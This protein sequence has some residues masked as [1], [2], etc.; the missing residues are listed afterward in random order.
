[1]LFHSGI[2]RQYPGVRVTGDVQW[3]AGGAAKSPEGLTASNV[4]LPRDTWV[5]LA[6]VKNVAARQ[7]LI[8][9]DGVEVA[10]RKGS[11]EA[12]HKMDELTAIGVFRLGHSLPIQKNGWSP[13]W[14]KNYGFEGQMAEVRIWNVV[15]TP[16]EIVAGMRVKT[17]ELPGKTG[18]LLYG[19]V[20]G[21]LAQPALAK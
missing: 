11:T 18:L 1:M 16:E 10:N 21:K 7:M 9:V 14:M 12:K 13:E 4:T 6:F 2:G 17:A 3:V 19:P 15:R 8:Y 20:K 5:H